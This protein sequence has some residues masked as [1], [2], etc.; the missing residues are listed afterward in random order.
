MGGFTAIL[1][2][3]LPSG[4]S[5]HDR[6]LLGVRFERYAGFAGRARRHTLHRQRQADVRPGARTTA[7]PG[8]A[9]LAGPGT[10]AGVSG[11]GRDERA[12]ERRK[13]QPFFA[14]TIPGLGKLLRDEI[15]AHPS[16]DPAGAPG[17]DGRADLVFFRQ[18]RGARFR[19]NDL[20]LAEDVFA[21]IGHARAGPPGRVAAEAITRTGLEHALSTRARFGQPP[22]SAMT[23]RAITRVE[24]EQRFRRTELR[25]AV[26][27]A[28][29]AERPRWRTADPAELEIWVLQHHRT[30]FVSGLRL[31]DKTMRQRGEGRAVE[32]HGALRPV[33]AA[34]MVYLAG[35]KP[36]RLLDPCCGT[37][38]ILSEA[39]A[40]GW[41]AT[42]SDIDSEAVA[43]ARANVPEANIQQADALEL[44][45]VSGSF[46]AF[47]ANLP[48]GRQFRV[49]TDPERWLSR[50][51][52][53]AI[54]VS[55]PGGRVVLLMPPP[56]PKAP[57]GLTLTESHPVR[58]LGTP[59]RIWIY[60][61]EDENS[62][63]AARA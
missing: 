45:H 42:G 48:F 44:P 59:A 23:I 31:S 57:A 12:S 25:D 34:A 29:S 33:I 9:R 5:D 38:T 28:I 52:P 50:A 53:E 61:R 10:F 19:L 24:D 20:R 51:L 32:R 35:R 62:P 3:T 30:Y 54:R 63:G 47:V 7:A 60:A 56:M 17:F 11:Q 40:V 21:E 49:D 18:R 16:L 55:R 2:K 6:R 43:I 39:L 46:D 13:G 22:R 41:D 8:R 4:I 14:T 37:G 15:T 1:W 36:G 58:V 26:L 27:R